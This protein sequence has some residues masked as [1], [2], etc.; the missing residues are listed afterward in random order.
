[1]LVDNDDGSRK[2]K[3]RIK[4]ELVNIDR[5]SSS[6]HYNFVDNLYI[7]FAPEADGANIEDLFDKETLDTVL[8]GKVLNRTNRSYEIDSKKE[9]SKTVFAEEVIR[10]KQKEINFGGFKPV[11]DEFKLIIDDYSK[12]GI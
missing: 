7:M 3:S 2:I 1:M 10:A 11:L 12:K 4:E 9:Y 8:D 6:L 5:V